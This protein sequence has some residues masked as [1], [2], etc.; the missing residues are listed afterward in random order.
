MAG[1][2]NPF[3][4]GLL[5]RCP[6]CGK[7]P[8]FAGLL[9]IA[10]ACSAC[11]RDFSAADPGDGPAV[12]VMFAVGALV[13]PLALI[14]ELLAGPPAWV[15]AVLWLP[16]ILALSIGLLRPVKALLVALQFHNDAAEAR[17]DQR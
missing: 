12:F 10:P 8:L 2:V 5:G 1:G 4:A 3:F 13:V 9:A 11:G 16:L 14:L 17:L 7:G 6:H 15:H